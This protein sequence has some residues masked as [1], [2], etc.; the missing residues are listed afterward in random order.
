MKDRTHPSP[1]IAINL[2]VLKMFL[3]TAVLTEGVFSWQLAWWIFLHD[4]LLLIPMS[5]TKCLFSLYFVLSHYRR[6]AFSLFHTTI[7]TGQIF[8]LVKFCFESV[9]LTHCILV[10]SSTVLKYVFEEPICHFRGIRSLLYVLFY[11]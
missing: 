7:T 3:F 4:F 8:E 2:F 1:C 10:S 5:L 9:H 11:F 6:L